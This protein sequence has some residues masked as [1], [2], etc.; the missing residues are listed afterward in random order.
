MRK[1]VNLKRVGLRKNGNY[2][3]RVA[4]DWEGEW[5][6]L[7]ECDREKFK[8]NVQENIMLEGKGSERLAPFIFLRGKDKNLTLE[9]EIIG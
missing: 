8:R 5:I 1:L 2:I 6:A 4:S 9:K 7:G 3:D